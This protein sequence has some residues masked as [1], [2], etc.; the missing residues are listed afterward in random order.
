MKISNYQLINKK[1]TNNSNIDKE[2]KDVLLYKINNIKDFNVG[3]NNIKVFRSARHKNDMPTIF[4]F[5]KVDDAMKDALTQ[6]SETGGSLLKNKSNSIISDHLTI[7][8]KS[9]NAFVITFLGGKKHL[10][11]TEIKVDNHG[12]FISLKVYAEINKLLKPNETFVT[13][14]IEIYRTNNV[15]E[16]IKDFA[17]KK[18]QNTSVKNK[19]R[20]ALY[21]TWYYYGE[22]ITL[23]DCHN[24]LKAIKQKKLPLDTFQI[25][26]GWEDYVGDW[27]ANNKFHDMKKVANEIKKYGLVPGIW[28]APF[29]ADKNSKLIKKHPDWILKDKQ[30]K[31][32]IFLMN[33]KERYIIDITIKETWA[34]FTKLYQRLTKIEGF[35]YHKLDFTRAPITAINPNYKNKY[36]TIIEAYRNACLSIRKG[37]GD[38]AF[39]L[40]CGG[41][42]DPTIGIVDAQRSGSDVLSMWSAMNRGGK[43]LP[44][45]IKQNVFRYYMNYW[46][47]NDPDSFIVRRNKEEYKGLRLSLGLLNDEE[48][49]T[50]TIN[51]LLGCGLFSMTEPLN[52]IDIDRLNN[53]YH[54]L[55]LKETE[56]E[57][58]DLLASPRFPNQIVINQ[59][60]L[61]LI[62]YSNK[63]T[64]T[65][66]IT[67]KDISI[68]NNNDT[69]W[70]IDFYSKKIS[71]DKI[72]VKLLPHSA[73]IIKLTNKKIES[74]NN[75]G[76]YLN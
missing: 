28:T 36:I 70:L 17:N 21:C 63:K 9:N 20:P 65:K 29:I 66:T 25:D 56:I 19:K 45:T 64:L 74:L 35:Q 59:K 4:T 39:F 7:I 69:C 26:D 2:V 5:G 62:N 75:R 72:N 11:H 13:E 71:K 48:V 37:M 16:A 40:M 12:N 49:K 22:T 47:H 44:Y 43:T 15:N 73:T 41:L 31:P 6:I 38:N 27:H 60:Y 52:E 51:Q 76:H 32:C 58:K 1:I 8:G 34:Y 46:W 55:P 53:I 30:H 68:I 57:V 50:A 23:E 3:S 18:I 33:H 10:I 54:V 14:D 24:N 67:R 61:A 42:Y